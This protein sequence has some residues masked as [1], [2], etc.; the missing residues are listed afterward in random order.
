MYLLGPAETERFDARTLALL[1]TTGQVLSGLD[2]PQAAA[3]ISYSRA[4]L[5]HDSGPTHLAAALSI[6]TLA[7]F[8]PSNPTHWQPLCPTTRI[9]CSPN[10]SPLSAESIPVDSTYNILQNTLK[11]YA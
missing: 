10:Q 5:G 2:I 4:F 8:G 9:I 7:I 6:P 1:N 3:L 11:F